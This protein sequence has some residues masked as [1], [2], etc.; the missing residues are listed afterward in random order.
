MTK[1]VYVD[2]SVI[3]GQFDKEF[4]LDTDL[5]FE[6]VKNGEIKMIISDLL[7]AELLRAPEQVRQFLRNFN[8]NCIERIQLTE[9]AM[10]LA[11]QYIKAKVVGKT[12]RAIASILLW[13]QLPDRM[14]W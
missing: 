11:D 1:R 6:A 12:S 9:E 3:G 14:Y 8:E 2:T 10:I 13:L 5:F 4:S 7:E